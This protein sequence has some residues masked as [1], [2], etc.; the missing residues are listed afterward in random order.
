[1]KESDLGPGNME[2][3]APE[4]TKKR[5]YLTGTEERNYTIP[6]QVQVQYQDSTKQNQQVGSEAPPAGLLFRLQ[7]GFHTVLSFISMLL[8]VPTRSWRR[9]RTELE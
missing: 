6:V 7:T 8:V 2:T 9:W 4:S 5:G 1:M 3:E